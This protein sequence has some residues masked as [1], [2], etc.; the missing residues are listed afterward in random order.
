MDDQYKDISSVQKYIIDLQKGIQNIPNIMS[1]LI[2]IL[3]KTHYLPSLGNQDGIGIG[4]HLNR[5]MENS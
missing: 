4:T 2:K 1:Y 3:T 5:I